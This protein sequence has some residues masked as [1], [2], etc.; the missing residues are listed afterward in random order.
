VTTAAQTKGFYGWW[1]LFFLWVVYT[2]PIGFAFYS[3]TVLYPYMTAE[4]GWAR[5]EVMVGATGVMMLFGISS[6][7]V[8]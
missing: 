2:V 7:L 4:T 5:G 6:P 1:M 3:G 8:A